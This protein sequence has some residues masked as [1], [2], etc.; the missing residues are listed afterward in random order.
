MTSTVSRAIA[1]AAGVLLLTTACSSSGGAAAS[2]ASGSTST[3]AAPGTSGPPLVSP[4]P[5]PPGMT[6]VH[7]GSVSISVPATMTAMSDLGS[8]AQQQVVGYRSAPDA[9]GTAGV[10]LVTLATAAT[11]SAEAEADALAGLKRDVVHSA[12]VRET[13]VTWPGFTSAYAVSYDDAP[14]TVDGEALHTLVVIAQTTSG[15]L[16]NV[17]AK[18]PAAL[19]ASLGLAASVASLAAAGTGA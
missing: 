13:P 16:V 11:R 10:V 6:T 18:A 7:V 19:F 9:D 15:P 17:T 4:A 1:L 2:G 12:A 8:D 14:T 3:G 5:A